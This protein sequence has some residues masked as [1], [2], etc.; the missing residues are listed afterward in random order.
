MLLRHLWPVLA[1]SALILVLSGIPG[2]YIPEVGT[3]WDWLGP[4]K[5]AHL[6]LFG[7]FSVLFLTGA[8]RQYQCPWLRSYSIPLVVI[9]GMIFGSTT[10]IMQ[11][12]VFTGRSG[13]WFDAAADTAGVFLGVL[14]Y[15]IFFKKHS[16]ANRNN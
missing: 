11:R 8:E 6:I 12:F 2:D 7:V 16:S 10:E 15:M 3:F 1:W 13:N 5:L 4:D 9:V 14:I